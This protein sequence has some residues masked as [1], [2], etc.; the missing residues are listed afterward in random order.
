[1]AALVV[2]VVKI[3]S[4]AVLRVGQIGTD[5]PVALFEFFGFEARPQTLGLRVIE[6]LTAATLRAQ[7][8][9]LV[10]QRPVSAATV[11]PTPVGMHEQARGGLPGQQGAT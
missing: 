9:V 6:P 10:E 2:I 7:T 8:P 1:M 4:H 5:R 11:L 3:S